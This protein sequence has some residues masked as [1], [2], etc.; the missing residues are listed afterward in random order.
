[1][2]TTI[3][4]YFQNNYGTVKEKANQSLEFRELYN[5]LSKRPLKRTLARLKTEERLNDDPEIIFV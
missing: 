1:M 2:Q 4:S 5:H 3:Y